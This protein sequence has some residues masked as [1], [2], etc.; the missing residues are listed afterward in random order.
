MSMKMIVLAVLLSIVQAPPPVPRQASGK[1]AH[2]GSCL[3]Q[4][5]DTKQS[6]ANHVPLIHEQAAV[7][8]EHNGSEPRSKNENQ[9]PIGIGQIPPVSVK[10]DVF[11]VLALV[12]TGA[13]LVVGSIGVYKAH[14]TLKAIKRQGVSLR[15]QTTHLKNSVTM[16]RRAAKA[17]SENA[18]AALLAT[19]SAINVTRARFYISL[20]G[21]I[22]GFTDSRIP[23]IRHDIFVL[24]KGESPGELI[25]TYIDSIAA[26]VGDI[27]AEPVFE[28]G[29]IKFAQGWLLKDDKWQIGHAVLTKEE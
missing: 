23:I 19:N 9:Q 22:G 10:R 20:D 26:S 4:N 18:K 8:T 7:P 17:A 28:A 25:S 2:S 3:K 6:I 16:A 12:F 14:Q 27:P 21:S 1:P 29:K 24:N 13:L 11:D 15:R 5:S